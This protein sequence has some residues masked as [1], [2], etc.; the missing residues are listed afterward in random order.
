MKLMRD[1]TLIPASNARSVMASSALELHVWMRMS[2]IPATTSAAMM[3]TAPTLSA[4]T[5]A[6]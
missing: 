3:L 4:H 1:Y 5:L 2:A 6:R